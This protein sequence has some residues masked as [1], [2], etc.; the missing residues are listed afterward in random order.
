MNFEQEY[1]KI[2][3]CKA[4]HRFAELTSYFGYD[5]KEPGSQSMTINEADEESPEKD[6][7]QLERFWE[8]RY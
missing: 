4:G 8:G 5:Y 3:C 1:E 6:P 2:R 7:I